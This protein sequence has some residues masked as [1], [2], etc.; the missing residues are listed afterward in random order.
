MMRERRGAAGAAGFTLLELLVAITLLGLLMAALF[1]GL[2]LGA[3]AWDIG[4]ERIAAATRLQTAQQFIRTRLSEAL[5]AFVVL[6]DGEEIVAFQGTS[7]EMS[8]VGTLPDL[9]IAVCRA[10]GRS[11]QACTILEANGYTQVA[12]L[13]GGMIKWRALRPERE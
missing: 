2:R 8:F 1:G 10:G 13:D 4:A 12:N 3:R 11:A 9:A 7:E 6:P 5:P